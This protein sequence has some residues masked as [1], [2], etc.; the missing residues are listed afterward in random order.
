MV[1]DLETQPLLATNRNNSTQAAPQQDEIDKTPKAAE[2]VTWRSE[3]KLI[4]KHSLPLICTY[5]LQYFYNLVI[6]LVCSTLST[7]ELAAVSLGI[8]TSNI[9]GYAV[10]E[11]LD[12][13]CAQAFGAGNIQLVG[14]HTLR[15]TIFVH[16]VAVPIGAIWLF[17]PQI[18][19]YVVPSPGLA[20]DASVFL[21]W[22]LI[23]VPGYATFEAG[24]RFMQAQGNFTSGLIVLIA[25]LPINIFFNWLLVFHL[26]MRVAG[27]ALAAALTNLVRPGLL[28]GYALYIN[29]AAL[30]CWPEQ[31][32]WTTLWSN[33]KPMVSLSI[34]STVMTLSEWMAFE[35]LT[36]ATSYVGTVDLAAQTFLATGVVVVW[37]MPF[38]ASVVTSTRLGQLIGGGYV[39]TAKQVS[40]Y[41]VFMFMGCGVLEMAIMS[42]I[43]ELVLNYLTV[44]EAVKAAVSGA[45]PF[46]I[47]FT[48][49]DCMATCLHGIIR[50]VGW[51]SIG[52]WV[53]LLGNYLYS[54]PLALV[55]ELGPPKLGLRGLWMAIA[56]GLALISITEG[57]L[58]RLRS[59][60]KLIDE[61]NE[62]QRA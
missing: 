25:C 59:W 3:T 16:L 31:L 47:I 10:F 29:P 26:D 11:A 32:K 37:H 54:V 52:G 5:L 23:G 43:L 41:Y 36:F 24:K 15:F 18:L 44:D 19:P 50:G 34:P 12:T 35:I 13:L 39:H 17:S 20:T 40:G 33:W 61:A 57:I 4:T 9:I 2:E 46:T 55:L 21:R 58:I 38:A 60:D 8:T 62:R 1:A 51:Q 56:S 48:F 14:L 49:F 28:I 27:A 42:G 7:E 6:V 22:S 45:M 30:Q 53:T